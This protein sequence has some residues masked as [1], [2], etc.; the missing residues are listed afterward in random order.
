MVDTVAAQYVLT[1]DTFKGKFK[2][3][4]EPFTDEYYG[5]LVNKGENAELLQMFNEG[6]LR[7]RQMV[8][9]MPSMPSGF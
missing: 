7:S 1:S 8:R 3:V 4:G 5:L 9:M 2:I 6:W